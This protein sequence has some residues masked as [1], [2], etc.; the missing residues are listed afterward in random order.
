MG[1]G[2]ESLTPVVPPPV[3][4]GVGM[5]MYSPAH[6]CTAHASKGLAAAFLVHRFIT[7][8]VVGVGVGMGLACHLDNIPNLEVH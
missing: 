7:V 8:D 4:K 1:V 2:V 6:W 5:A 3:S